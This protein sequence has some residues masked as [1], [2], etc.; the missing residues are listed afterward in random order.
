MQIPDSTVEQLALLIDLPLDPQY[1]PG[2]GENF[3]RIRSLA[4]LVL[5]FPLP[6]EIQVA[7]VFQP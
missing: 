4:Q 7:P 6:D 2:V 1:L 5:E 3:H